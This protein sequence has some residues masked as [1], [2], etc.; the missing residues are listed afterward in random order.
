MKGPESDEEFQ[1]IVY[2]VQMTCCNVEIKVLF[3]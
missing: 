1:G 3:M 2:V